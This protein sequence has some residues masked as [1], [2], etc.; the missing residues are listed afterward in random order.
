MKSGAKPFLSLEMML[1]LGVC[2]FYGS[3]S[4]LLGLLNKS[5]LSS[6]DFQCI[7]ILLSAQM[8]LQVVLCTV[9]RD[10]MRNPAG[11]PH[12][13]KAVHYESLVLG[14]TYVAN[15]A[16]GLLGLSL[17]NVPMFFCIRRLVSPTIL[18]YE[19]LSQG[20]VA[21]ANV[22]A[23]VGTIMVGTLIA[24]WDT[25]SS[26]IVGYSITFL[27]NLCTAASSVSQKA[28]CDKTKLGALGTLYYTSLTALPL[29]LLMALVFGEFETLMAF[30]HL[31]DGGFWFGFAVALSLG[32]LLTYSSILC[33]TYNSPLAMSITGNIKDL[34]STV[35]GA[36]LFKGF[37]A[38]TKSVGG[39]GLTFVGA[40]IYSYINLKKGQ[41]KAAS[42]GGGGGE[43]AMA[44]P[45][46]EGSGAGALGAGAGAAAA[47]AE[48]GTLIA[49]A[50]TGDI[51]LKRGTKG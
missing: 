32:P 1:S 14:F 38:T 35:L 25:L 6:Y 50:S 19:Y 23:A 3:V 20:K 7:F 39:L 33:T 8:L 51:S 17:V 46:A 24:G 27:N 16:V 31:H 40:G 43:T 29:S 28:F 44:A 13:D 36:V 26:D 4:L 21:D 9:S 48:Q 10:Y 12:Y 15:V 45:A 2:V 34:A 11:I 37:V 42:A 49:P 18:L 22:Q 47:D 41:A 5:L 30:K